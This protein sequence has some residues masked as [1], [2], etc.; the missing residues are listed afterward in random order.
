MGHGTVDALAR[1]GAGN[2][3]LRGRLVQEHG[4]TAAANACNHLHNPEGQDSACIS[5]VGC[6]VCHNVIAFVMSL[7]LAKCCQTAHS[8]ETEH[9]RGDQGG[10]VDAAEAAATAA[11]EHAGM[12][13]VSTNGDAQVCSSD[14]NE[15]NAAESVD[16]GEAAAKS[17]FISI[18]VL[19]DVF[20]VFISLLFIIEWALPEPQIVEP[21]LEIFAVYVSPFAFQGCDEALRITI[22]L[23]FGNAE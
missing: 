2:L 19:V 16:H 14:H 5:H 15:S 3:F 12:Q 20:C 13:V 6:F 7:S 11:A 23:A 8:V 1:H 17:N 21:I 18:P 10:K 9:C 22:S 4:G